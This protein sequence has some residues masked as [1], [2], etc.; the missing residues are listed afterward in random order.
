MTWKHLFSAGFW[1]LAQVS[2]EAVGDSS[3]NLTRDDCA[4][5]TEG[6]CL[7]KG[8]IKYQRPNSSEPTNVRV[9][10]TVE[11]LTSV[12]DDKFT[13]SLDIFLSLYWIDNRLIY[14]GNESNKVQTEE[15]YN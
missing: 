8:Y 12:N 13:V 11:Q 9:K 14:I 15:N 2:T 4:I 6:F 7:P 3:V 1:V 5:I 10:F